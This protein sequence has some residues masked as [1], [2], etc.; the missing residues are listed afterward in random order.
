MELMLK[1]FDSHPITDFLVGLS[2]PARANADRDGLIETLEEIQQ[3]VGRESAETPA[4]PMRNLG[5]LDGRKRL[6]F[7]RL[8]F[9]IRNELMD[10]ESQLRP[11]IK[12]VGVVKPQ[13]GEDVSRAFFIL[14]VYLPAGSHLLLTP[15]PHCFILIRGDQNQP[16]AAA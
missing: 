6:D 3:V 16:A 12:L 13:I 5:L 10:V 9:P 14:R 11:S 15:S 2:R 7:P 1:P 4:H 8:K